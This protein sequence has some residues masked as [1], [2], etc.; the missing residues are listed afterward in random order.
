MFARMGLLARHAGAHTRGNN[1]L[2]PLSE[3]AL[4]VRWLSEAV[5]S[6]KSKTTRL[7]KYYVNVALDRFLGG[8][9]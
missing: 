1:V 8:S 5:I 7:P 2:R 9:R 4:R 3:N 6:I